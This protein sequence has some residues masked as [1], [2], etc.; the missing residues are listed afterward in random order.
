MFFETWGSERKNETSKTEGFYTLN[1]TIF[2]F[3]ITY[4]VTNINVKM[5]EI[6]I[7]S[8][9]QLLLQITVLVFEVVT[10]DPR[11]ITD[12]YHNNIVEEIPET[13]QIEDRMTEIISIVTSLVA[14]NYGLCSYKNSQT[15][16]PSMLT[17]LKLILR[18]SVDVIG[19]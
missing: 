6:S 18:S 7:E 8:T 5:Y 2:F 9:T 1:L 14:I 19:R 15:T 3:L 4:S 12:S 17:I 16:N 13:I 11:Y 10:T